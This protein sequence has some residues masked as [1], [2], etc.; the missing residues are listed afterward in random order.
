MGVILWTELS[1]LTELEAILYNVLIFR[2]VRSVIEYGCRNYDSR[3]EECQ[4]CFEDGKRPGQ[5]RNYNVCNT[6]L[7]ESW[8]VN[9]MVC[10]NTIEIN[11][12]DKIISKG[13]DIN[14]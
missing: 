6:K 5:N 13:E 14:E 4:E 3:L 12:D 8:K 2:C 10:K 9:R 1:N 11:K 7:H